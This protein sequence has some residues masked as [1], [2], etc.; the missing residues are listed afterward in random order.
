LV[1]VQSNGGRETVAFWNHMNSID[2]N[3]ALDQILLSVR[4]SSEIWII[5]HSTT[6]TEAAGH[7]G[8]KSG[9][10]GDLLYRWGN[11]QAYGT[12]SANSQQLFQ[13]HDAQWIDPGLPGAGNILIFNN[14]LSRPGGIYS[15]VDE[16]VPPVDS[17]GSYTRTSGSAFGPSNM[18]LSP[19]LSVY[20]TAI[21]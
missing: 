21:P 3:P 20:P 17:T 16:I 19:G 7:G 14:G 15:T 5:D 6:M 13:Q 11:P 4:G 12:G 1:D 9:K 10:G 18:R 8:G 2:Y